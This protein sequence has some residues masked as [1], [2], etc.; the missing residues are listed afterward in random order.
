MI[1]PTKK[2]KPENSLVYVGGTLLGLL[3]EPKTVSRLWEEFQHQRTKHLGIDACDIPFDWF[4]LALNLLHLLG[5]IDLAA[6]RL[7]KL[8]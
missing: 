6:G 1:L 4:V 7:V 3:D 5:A 8:G 2:L